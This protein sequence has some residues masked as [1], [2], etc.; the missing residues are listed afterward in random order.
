MDIDLV[1]LWV[2]GSDPAWQAKRNTF[3]G[4]GFESTEGDCKGRYTDN[5]ELRYNLRA[6]EKY[7]PWI[8]RIFIVTDDQTPSW[9]KVT[10]PKIRIVNHSDILP[11]IS[12]PCFNSALIEHFIYRIPDLSEHFIYANDDT[13]INK[14]VTPDYFFAADGRPIVRFIHTRLRDMYLA[15]RKKF[16]GIPYKYYIQSLRNSAELIRKKYGIYYKGKPHHN[17][18]AYVK[19]NCQ[20]IGKVF[21]REL[22][23]ML[24][25]HVRTPNDIQR[26]I[27]SYAGLAEMQWHVQYVTQWNSFRLHIQ[28]RYQYNKLEIYDP[29]LFC[30]NDS[31]YATDNDRLKVTDFL[32]KRFPEKSQYEI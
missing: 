20:H 29:I 10:N 3:T 28:N 8:H 16:L 23:G 26:V 6:V 7:A 31:E 18:D 32:S 24:T 27:Y 17:I 12:R 9:L 19:S 15:F 5:D 25:N 4:T 30:I 22:S 14:P 2:D 13:F 11:D 21:E 1:Y